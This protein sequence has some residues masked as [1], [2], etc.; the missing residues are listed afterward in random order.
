MIHVKIEDGR[1]INL[2]SNN[3]C[4]CGGQCEVTTTRTAF[5]DGRPVKIHEVEYKDCKCTNCKCK[6]VK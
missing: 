2:Y 3:G 5:E 6:G 1:P 4:N